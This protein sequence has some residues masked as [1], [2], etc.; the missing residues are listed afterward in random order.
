MKSKVTLGLANMTTLEKIETTRQYVIKMT[1]NANFTTPVPS[2]ATVTA[3]VNTLEV[4][5]NNAKTG[6]QQQTAIMYDKEEM[7]DKDLNQLAAYVEYTA[8]GDRSIILSAGMNIK[9]NGKGASYILD[10]QNGENSGEVILTCPSLKGS[11]YVWQIKQNPLNTTD[12]GNWN[13]L[14]TATVAKIIVT[15][16]TPGAK[17]WFRVSNIVKDVEGD[18]S[19]PV[20]IIVQ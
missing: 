7:L 13:A 6:G 18:W 1:G 5:Y 12:D 11:A 4:A 3:A 19:D 2:L 10:A 16:L 8:N 9:K 14:K 17:Y 20:S 15:D